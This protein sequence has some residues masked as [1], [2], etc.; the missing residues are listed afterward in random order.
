M[1]NPH[2]Y[3]ICLI[4]SAGSYG[5]VRSVDGEWPVCPIAS[6]EMKYRLASR[7]RTY[8][9]DDSPLTSEDVLEAEAGL[10]GNRRGDCN[11]TKYC[12]KLGIIAM[13][14]YI[15]LGPIMLL[16][17]YEYLS[18]P[19]IKGLRIKLHTTLTNPNTIE[20]IEKKAGLK[21]VSLKQYGGL[22]KELEDSKAKIAEKEKELATL[23]AKK[24]ELEELTQF[25]DLNAAHA[26]FCGDC[27]W[28]GRVS[29][30]KR[31]NYLIRTYGTS[32]LNALA[33]L[34]REKQCKK[35]VEQ[36]EL[37]QFC[38]DC[39]WNGGITCE[40][41]KTYL[42]KKYHCSEEEALTSVLNEPKCQKSMK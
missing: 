29:C 20:A 13:L 8:D 25:I 5:A 34:L 24:T 21:I 4:P 17:S 41:R 39:K 7:R 19:F 9:R 30:E 28:K 27:K 38:G 40:A 26:Q 33:N 10:K 1:P 37:P 14:A 36:K 32:E 6:L 22:T 42:I 11:A 23:A 16:D 31:K 2:Q 35:F 12:R 15:I 3:V 18:I